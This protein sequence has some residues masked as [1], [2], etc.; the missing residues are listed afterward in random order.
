MEVSCGGVTI[1][2]ASTIQYLGLTLD[3][4]L[5]FIEH[6]KIIQKNIS[7]TVRQLGYSLPNLGGA[8]QWRRRLLGN[9]AISQMLYG[10]TCWQ[11]GMATH[12]WK[13][14][15]KLQRKIALRIS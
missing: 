5:N 14:L 13:N 10:V 1:R 8:K 7:N 6:S 4:K 9:V 12:G 2:S 15:E 11:S 3:N